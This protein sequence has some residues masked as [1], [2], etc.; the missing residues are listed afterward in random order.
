[1]SFLWVP[2]YLVV[3]QVVDNGQ[4]WVPAS[5]YCIVYH[6][7]GNSTWICFSCFMYQ[8]R[9]QYLSLTSDLTRVVGSAILFSVL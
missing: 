5:W 1:M 2:E 7:L 9:H 3:V 6:Q 8:V 4:V